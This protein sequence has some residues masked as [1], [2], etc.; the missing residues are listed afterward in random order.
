MIVLNI[1]D[2][3]NLNFSYKNKQIFNDFNFK[4]KEGSFTTVAGSCGSGKTTLV[5]IILG[6]IS[7]DFNVKICGIKMNSENKKEIRKQIGVVFENPDNSFVAETVIDDI[8][9]T[10]ENLNT[11]VEEIKIRVENI[12]KQLKI[13]H[14]LDLNPYSLSGGEKQLVS[15]ASALITDPKILIL[16]ESLSML[17]C[18]KKDEILKYL[19]KI[20]RENKITIINITQDLEESI[21]GKKI[22][23]INNGKV[24]LDE[25]ISSAFID[26]KI[27]KICNLE[28]PFLASLSNKL[29]YYGLVDEVILDM[30]KMVNKLWK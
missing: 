19:K 14:L 24:V 7:N 3:D 29:K 2:I 23:L 16:D 28:V 11:P 12:T 17:D 22:I 21:Y 9:F 15:L 26:E 8:T 20:N 25:K 5:K 10:L 13:E 27:Y 4:I 1:I 6:L 18:L 30:G